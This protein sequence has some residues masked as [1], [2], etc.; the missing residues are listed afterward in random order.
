MYFVAVLLYQRAVVS[1]S[2]R[3][4]IYL[5][6]VVKSLDIALILVACLA[7][8]YRI[9]NAIQKVR[10]PIRQ[11]RAETAFVTRF[12]A[13]FELGLKQPSIPLLPVT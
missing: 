11:L 3:A 1:Q 9:Y 8:F 4:N 5:D 7:I 6:Y 13:N 2:C 12:F 10:R